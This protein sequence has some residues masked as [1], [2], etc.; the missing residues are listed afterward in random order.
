MKNEGYLLIDH[1]ASP[2]LTPEDFRKAGITEHSLHKLGLSMAEFGEGKR[3]ERATAR[4]CHCGKQVFLNS[5][6]VQ[7][8]SFCRT[9]PPGLDYVCDDPKCHFDCAPYRKM[10]D[11]LRNDLEKAAKIERETPVPT[12]VTLDLPDAP[13]KETNNG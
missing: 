10:L 7:P 9:C 5:E 2:G 3:L 1:Q 6:R 12:F 13:A 4:C 8:R 11:R